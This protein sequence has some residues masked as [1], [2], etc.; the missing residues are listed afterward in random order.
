MIAT[1]INSKRIYESL[2]SAESGKEVFE[3]LCHI[4]TDNLGDM[5]AMIDFIIF[6]RDE[7]E[8]QD[9]TD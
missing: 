6:K 2:K 4:P 8:S 9:I 1:N 3:A 7:A 5:K